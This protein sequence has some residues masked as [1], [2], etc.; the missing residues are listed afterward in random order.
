M[1]G[2]PLSS[3]QTIADKTASE[4]VR[5]IE[6]HK[7]YSISFLVHS[8]HMFILM[9]SSLLIPCHLISLFLL[10]CSSSSLKISALK[11]LNLFRE[12]HVM[13]EIASVGV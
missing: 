7:I 4:K 9:V 8:Y 13:V 11:T 6:M 2:L 12:N 3:H 5:Y 1:I 10:Q